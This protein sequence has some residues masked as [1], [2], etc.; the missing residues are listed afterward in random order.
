MI[1]TTDYKGFIV[2]GYNNGKFSKVELSQ[3]STKSNRKQLKKAYCLKGGLVFVKFFS[4]EENAFLKKSD[5]RAEYEVALITDNEKALVFDLKHVQ[6]VG[7]RTA[8]GNT[9]LKLS[10]LDFITSA[11]LLFKCKLDDPDFYRIQTLPA[12]GYYLKKVD[13]QNKTTLF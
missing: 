4:E 3:Y 6:P 13:S 2:Y 9:I 1:A 5:D 8:Q 10:K 12:Q 11:A 7:S